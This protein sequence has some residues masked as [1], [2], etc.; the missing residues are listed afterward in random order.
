LHDG[1][2]YE[3]TLLGKWVEALERCE[4]AAFVFNAYRI[5][6]TQGRELEI[7]REAFPSCFPGSLLLDEFFRRWGFGSPVWGTVMARKAAYEDAGLFQA[8]FGD[9]ADVDMWL[10][11]AGQYPVAYV[12]EPLISLPSR[13]VSPRRSNISLW[14]QLRV[15]EAILWESRMRHFRDRP[16]RKGVE[17]IRHWAFVAIHRTYHLILAARRV[18]R[19]R[20]DDEASWRPA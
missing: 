5:L 8:R 18:V 14:R 4:A 16:L 17:V 1:D 15:G 13:K 9:F 10:R 2:L 6:D 20:R 19:G 12:D 7:Y 3:R 11:L